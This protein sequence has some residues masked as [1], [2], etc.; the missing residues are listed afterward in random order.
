[1]KKIRFVVSYDGTDYCGWQKQKEHAYAS[2]LPSIQETIENSLQKIFQHPIRLSGSGRTD[3]GV[4]A[5]A[6]VCHFET[7]RKIPKDLCWALRSQLPESIAA[8][9]AYIAPQEFHATLSAEK[10]TY[11]YWIWN[12]NRNSALLNRYSWWV[13]Q[14]LNIENL[15]ARSQCLLGE[16]DFASF[17][18]VGTEVKHTIRNIY[19]MDWSQRSSGLV[20]LKITG[21]GFMKQMVRN[22]VGTIVDNEV[23]SQPIDIIEEI[24]EKKHRTAAG[25]TA[26]A[27][28]LFLQKVYY[29]VELDNKCRRI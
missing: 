10:K 8:K 11:K 2:E 21:N 15:R 4:H 13:R 25:P 9:V 23:K 7:D 5:V 26:P 18:S 16:K 17:K 27:Q 6:Q 29:P 24:L 12:S 22:I 14:P 28:G 3:A 1:M 20:E 19:K